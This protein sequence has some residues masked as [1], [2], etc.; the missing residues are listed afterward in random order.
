MRMVIVL[1]L[2]ALAAQNDAPR[3]RGD[4]V[5]VAGCVR[6]N[7]LKLPVGETTAVAAAVQASEYI[8]EGS[9]ELL[10][11]LRKDH[12]GHYEEVTGTL[13]IPPTAAGD[14]A[15][16]QKEFGSRTRVT[17]GARKAPGAE[18]PVPVRLVVSSYRHLADHCSER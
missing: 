16:R 9:N 4:L 11:T 12:D 14:T 7:H 17:L 1:V 2:L 18:I 6:G 3:N 5:T 8:L 13:K 10:R 15:I